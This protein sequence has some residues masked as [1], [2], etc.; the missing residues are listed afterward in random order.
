MLFCFFAL[1]LSGHSPTNHTHTHT[2]QLHPKLLF[3]VVSQPNTKQKRQKRKRRKTRQFCVL[4]CCCRVLSPFFLLETNPTP[5]FLG[6]KFVTFPWN[7]PLSGSS[8]CRYFQ[9]RKEMSTPKEESRTAKAAERKESEAEEAESG[10]EG[11]VEH[12]RDDAG[13]VVL[14]MAQRGEFKK[15]G[16][17]LDEAGTEEEKRLL[18]FSDEDGYT[19]LH[20]ASY[21]GRVRTM[22]L[23][24]SRSAKHKA[25]SKRGKGQRG[26]KRRTKN[27]K[28]KS[29]HI[30][31][32][33]L[34]L[35][36]SHT[37]THTLTH[38]YAHTHSHKLTLTQNTH[39]LSA[40]ARLALAGAL[41]WKRPHTTAGDRYTAPPAGISWK[42]WSCCY[43]QAQTST[44]GHRAA[45]RPS[46]LLRHGYAL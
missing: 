23:L 5:L 30:H 46:C 32:Y 22:R 8:V 10:E 31:T 41:M 16:D 19:A 27:T 12:G 24:L 4:L 36:H 2:T 1:L 3:L 20:R 25:Q 33:T 45:S 39:S 6:A 29:N 7:L 9:K 14:K 28:A 21:N 26:G 13:N 11:E 38:T 34:S 18:A 15:L 40:S 43:G 35:T 42:Q 37:L 17:F 44:L